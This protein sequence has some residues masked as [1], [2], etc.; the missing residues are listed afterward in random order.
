MRHTITEQYLNKGHFKHTYVKHI[1]FTEID[2]EASADNPARI[3]R[4]LDEE[5]A[6]R[7]R[8]IK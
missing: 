5:L 3:T 2:L 7:S 4:K 1:P 8:S 6:I